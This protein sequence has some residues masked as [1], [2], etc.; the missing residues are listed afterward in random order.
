MKY[1]RTVVNDEII[2]KDENE[3]KILGIGESADEE[4]M[5]YVLEGELLNEIAYEVEDELIAGLSVRSKVKIDMA[6]LTYIASVGLRSF[7]KIQHM[8]DDNPSAE[9]IL[10]NVNDDIKNIFIQNGFLELFTIE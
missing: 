8:I 7:L 2:I 4:Y 1:S 3:N 10:I 5:Y 9:M 6:R